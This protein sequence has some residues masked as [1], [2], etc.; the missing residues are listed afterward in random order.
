ME[1]RQWVKGWE[2]RSFNFKYS[3]EG[4]IWAKHLKE[5]REKGYEYIWR[6]F[7]A[8]ETA[9]AMTLKCTYWVQKQQTGWYDWS[10]ASKSY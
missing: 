4:D 10:Q 6:V 7:S 1:D 3:C 5:V 9:E 8:A 2:E